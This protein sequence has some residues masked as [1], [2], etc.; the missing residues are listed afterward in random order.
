MN[1]PRILDLRKGAVRTEMDRMD[2]DPM[3][4]QIMEDKGYHLVIKFESIDLRA[5]L[6]LKQDMLSLGGEAALARGAASLKLKST[7]V[8]LIGTVKQLLSLSEKVKSQ[9]FGLERISS[10]LNRLLELWGIHPAFVVGGNDLISDGNV[11]VMGIINVTDDSFSDGGDFLDLDSAVKRGLEMFS[12]GADIIDVGGESTRP[13]SRSID[14]KTELARVI[15]VIEALNKSGVPVISVDTT[16]SAVAR[17]AIEAG[18]TIIN[19]ISGM[20]FDSDMPGVAASTGA[21]VVLMHTRGSPDEMQDDLEYKDLMAEV[22]GY[23]GNAVDM[24]EKAGI[25]REKMCVDPGIGFGK[26]NEQNLEL[27]LRIGELRSLGTAVMVGASRKSFIGH[28][29]NV[30]VDKRL[31]GSL[32]SAVAAVLHG[33]NIVRAHDVRE[34]VRAATIANNI[35]SAGK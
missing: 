34:T 32:A 1:R 4:I 35:L 6:I 27:L 18:A 8:L 30:E 14:E 11:A 33:A 2:V 9:P 15:P 16:K 12:E 26:S 31:E 10:S 5:A 19:D 25:E 7:P 24:A 23:L 21:S 13:G 28:Y 20:N 22:F 17:K 3:G 29:L